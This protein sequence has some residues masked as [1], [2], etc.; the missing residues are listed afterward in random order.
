MTL[1]SQLSFFA[2]VGAAVFLGLVGFLFSESARLRDAQLQA[3]FAY[4]QTS[5]LSL[6]SALGGEVIES[7][8]SYPVQRDR[9]A[10]ESSV[11]AMRRFLQE[12]DALRHREQD[13]AGDSEEGREGFEEDSIASFRC[14]ILTQR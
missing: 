3:S 2:G 6:L 11:Q 12:F 7:I 10:V 8:S 13:H 5:A 14:L 9:K 1:R 4:E